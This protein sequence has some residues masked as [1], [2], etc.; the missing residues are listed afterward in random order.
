MSP[1]NGTSRSAPEFEGPQRDRAKRSKRVVFNAD[2]L[3]VSHGTNEGIEAAFEGGLIK[4]ASLCV[5]GEAFEEG[6]AL[7][8]RLAPDLGVGLHL[9]FTLGR[10]V[11]GPIRGLTDAEG[12]FLPLATVLRR[13]LFSR[14][15]R[16]RIAAEIEAQIQRAEE[17]GIELT[18][19]NGHHHVHV[20]P[21]IGEALR[22]VLA[23][24]PV[25]Y[26]RVPLPPP[27]WK[28]PFRM[29]L[30]TF[31][32]RRFCGKRWS[33]PAVRVGLPLIGLGV[34]G[35]EDYHRKFLGA[36]SR[37]EDGAYEWMVHPRMPD[38]VFARMDHLDPKIEELGRYELETLCDPK[39]QEELAALGIRSCRYAELFGPPD[40]G[41]QTG[42]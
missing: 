12:T 31:L 1:R 36:A 24:R 38:P 11:T 21:Q 17:A 9:S 8:R 16:D 15:D 40:S 6:A 22:D 42:S 35:A 18:H 13:T 7:A 27:W 4:E 37:L 5:T 29:N 20:Y 33:L 30:L 2:D 14:L 3:G 25:P 39:I 26:L 32:S 19:L 10:A 28:K 23:R 41:R 34:F